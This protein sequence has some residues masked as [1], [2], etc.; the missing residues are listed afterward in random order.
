MDW[1]ALKM[2]RPAED[3][4]D[5]ASILVP[6][7]GYKCEFAIGTTYSLDLEA[8]IGVPL[9]L[10]LGEEMDGTLLENPVYVLEALRKSADRFVLF[11]EGG[12]IKVPN[13]ANPVFALLESSIFE[14]VL[15][16]DVGG[17]PAQRDREQDN[18]CLSACHCLLPRKIHNL[19][20]AFR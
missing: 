15:K 14:V 17:S 7:A 11:C 12:Q 8:L 6:P 4:L 18:L 16:K 5:Y 1:G 3:R 9:A 2:F 19:P 10:F 13:K 20:F